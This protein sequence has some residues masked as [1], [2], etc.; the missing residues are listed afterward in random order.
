[1]QC[2]TSRLLESE[3]CTIAGVNSDTTIANPGFI[4][5]WFENLTWS[6]WP[7]KTSK[8]PIIPIWGHVE[9]L[10]T[11]IWFQGHAD[12]WPWNFSII[13]L[14]NWQS[15]DLNWALKISV[16]NSI[17]E[18]S[19]PKRNSFWWNYWKSPLFTI[20][21]DAR[22]LWRWSEL[23]IE[24]PQNRIE[25]S[26]EG[27][28]LIYKRFILKISPVQKLRLSKFEMKIFFMISL[29]C[30]SVRG[31]SLGS[32][33]KNLI[34]ETFSEPLDHYTTL[35]QP[36]RRPCAFDD[37]EKS[38]EKFLMLEQYIKFNRKCFK[39]VKSF[40]FLRFLSRQKCWSE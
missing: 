40:H 5:A 38:M 6:V 4:F 32:S 26:K 1:M 36:Q 19:S 9:K 27:Q 35:L 33:R 29:A 13:S 34:H 17:I 37:L 15:F 8:W 11:P 10:W 14:S 25:S 2:L 28:H 16:K 31:N 22:A 18:T 39:S 23:R 21:P 7:W 24:I 30:I 12:G 20:T 3:S